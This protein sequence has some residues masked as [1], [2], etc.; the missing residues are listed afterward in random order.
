M[1]G[2]S[3]APRFPPDR[4]GAL[5]R[6]VRSFGHAFGGIGIMF[7]EPSFR[8]QLGAGVIVLIAAAVFRVSAA[9]WLALILVSL[10]VLVMEMLNTVVEAVVDLASPGYSPLARRA[11]DVAAG[12]V[13]VTALGSVIVGVY[14]FGPR[15]LHLLR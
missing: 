9:E 1:E 13:L 8:I 6:R 12:A 11:K 3:S 15:I 2:G 5:A 14:I 7:G 10:A 4:P